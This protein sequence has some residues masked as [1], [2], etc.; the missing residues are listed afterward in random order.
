MNKTKTP[1]KMTKKGQKYYPSECD[2]FYRDAY[3]KK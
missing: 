2:E 3:K 1:K